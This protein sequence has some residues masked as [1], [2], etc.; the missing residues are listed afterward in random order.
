MHGLWYDPGM[1]S[2]RRSPPTTSGH[3]EHDREQIMRRPL[4][5]LAAVKQVISL[6]PDELPV[7]DHAWIDAQRG[8]QSRLRAER[9]TRGLTRRYAHWLLVEEALCVAWAHASERPE[10]IVED[11]HS[12]PMMV[13]PHPQGLTLAE[14]VVPGHWQLSMAFADRLVTE[15]ERE[16]HLYRP[17][18]GMDSA[19]LGFGHVACEYL[20]VD[21][22]IEHFGLVGRVAVMSGH[23]QRALVKAIGHGV[24]AQVALADMR[25]RALE[26]VTTTTLTG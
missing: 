21:P 2:L 12:R 22:L 19:A 8:E 5:S 3:C 18:E 13:V 10:G 14:Q 1:R 17:D 6:L 26:T 16:E 15:C 4:P 9:V 25:A 20:R 7:E 23:R 24:Y 11:L